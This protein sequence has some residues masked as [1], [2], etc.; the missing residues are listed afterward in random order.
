[1]KK[2]TLAGLSGLVIVF[3]T[4]F[5]IVRLG[6]VP[7]FTETTDYLM[8]TVVTVKV[9]A[10]PS[11]HTDDIIARA[12]T[13]AKRL[14]SLMTPLTGGG[15]LNRINDGEPDTW[16]VIDPELEEVLLRARY[17]FELTDGAFDPTIAAVKWLWD[18][19]G[20]AHL[21]ATDDIER[22]LTTVGFENIKIGGDSVNTG[23]SGTKLDLGGIAKGYIVDRMVA[24]LREGGVIGCLVN[25]GGD[26]YTFGRK[27][28][29]D[30]W[31][32]GFRHPRTDESIA[33]EA[34]PL[35]AVATSGDY[36]RYFMDGGKRYHHILD[37]GTGY[38]ADGCVSVTVWTATAMDA[39][40]LATGLFVL[41]HERGIALAEELEDVEALIFWEDDGVLGYDMT[42]GVR[43]KAAL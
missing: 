2:R 40:A 38:P 12:F 32:I 6:G 22:A 5:A 41:G 33:L 25:A 11:V 21:P 16:W 1:M 30:D 37:P 34:M 7:R 39:D 18:F 28:G 13:E 35:P 23:T 24:I 14:E 17:F 3:V 9:Y 36:E 26:I 15:E 19:E 27:A 20:E 4:V 42:S 31:V 10:P 29:G 8:D 43:G